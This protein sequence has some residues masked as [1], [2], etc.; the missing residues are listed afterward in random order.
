MSRRRVG[1]AA[2][3]FELA[4]QAGAIVCLSEYLGKKKVVLAFFAR[5]GTPG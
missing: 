4:D 2:P 5:A 1:E 3:P